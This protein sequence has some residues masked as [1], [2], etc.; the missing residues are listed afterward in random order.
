MLKHDITGVLYPD[1]GM[2]NCCPTP[3]CPQL[4]NIDCDSHINMPPVDAQAGFRSID[5]A[6][7]PPN[8]VLAGVAAAH[9]CVTAAAEL[10]CCSNCDAA[11][12]DTAV[13]E[14]ACSCA[15]A[16]KLNFC[17]WRATAGG[18][19]KDAV[20]GLPCCGCA[21]AAAAAELLCCLCTATTGAAAAL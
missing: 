17:M 4:S 15:A 11:G 13:R 10:S 9:D 21:A 19:A 5:T 12:V 1:S 16:V 8:L 14:P 3:K 18:A 2:C 20:A 7:V 6:P